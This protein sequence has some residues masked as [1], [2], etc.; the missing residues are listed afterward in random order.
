MWWSKLVFLTVSSSS[1]S[2]NILRPWGWLFSYKFFSSG[3]RA[4]LVVKSICSCKGCL[5]Y[6][7]NSG[8]SVTQ[9]PVDLTPSSDLIGHDEW[10]WF[11]C[12]GPLQTPKDHQGANSDAIALGSFYSSS[13]LGPTAVSDAAGW[14]GKAPAQLQASIYRGE[15]TVK[16]VSSLAHI[17]VGGCYGIVLP[18]K[19]IGRCWELMQIINWTCAFLLIAGVRKWSAGDRLD[20]E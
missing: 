18:F 16:G 3:W 6:S 5:F 10:S 15:H 11:T 1:W 19:V 12:C 4:G 13:S 17:W 2:I 8:L 20:G 14:E 7:P 9:I